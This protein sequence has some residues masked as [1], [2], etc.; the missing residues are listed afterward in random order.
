MVL[1]GDRS[2]DNSLGA[3]GPAIA[4]ILGRPH[5]TGIV[6]LDFSNKKNSIIAHHRGH[7]C[8]YKVPLPLSSVMCIR[9]FT[10]PTSTSSLPHREGE[11]EVFTA[12]DLALKKKVINERR[13]F[14]GTTRKAKKTQTLFID[15][16]AELA[17]LLRSNVAKNK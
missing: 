11:I 8:I 15:S 9:S 17:R 7:N 12:T 6:D 1:C 14:L 2:E 13:F 4:E 16:S 3:V 10:P 5:L